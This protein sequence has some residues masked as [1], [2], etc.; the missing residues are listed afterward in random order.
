[1][2]KPIDLNDYDKVPELIENNCHDCAF[3]GAPNCCANI[4][5]VACGEEAII[6]VPKL[7]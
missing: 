4:D 1:M 7:N 2:A 5:D 6:Y 3:I